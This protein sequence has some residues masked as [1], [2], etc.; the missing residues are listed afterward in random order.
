MD[1]TNKQNLFHIKQINRLAKLTPH[2]NDLCKFF[3]QTR[4]AAS[5]G[6]RT[7]WGTQAPYV[8]A[9]N[10][11]SP[12]TARGTIIRR[13]CPGAATAH[14]ATLRSGAVALIHRVSESVNTHVHSPSCV[15]YGLFEMAAEAAAADPAAPFEVNLGALALRFHQ[16]SGQAD[17][18]TTLVNASNQP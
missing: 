10:P 16:A 5:A 4:R 8:G 13:R 12:Q 17:S 15:V 9:R 2:L 11:S 18:G 7:N 1:K 14:D 3:R 6:H